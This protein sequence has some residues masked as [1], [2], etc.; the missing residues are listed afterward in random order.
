MITFA[1]YKKKALKDPKVKEMYDELQPDY[2]IIQ[3]L[4]DAKNKHHITQKEL[5]A[6]TG[7]NQAYITRLEKGLANTNLE[8][9]FSSERL[10]EEELESKINAGIPVFGKSLK[11]YSDKM[12][13]GR[14][15]V[16]EG[17]GRVDLLTKDELGNLYVIELKKDSGYE[18]SPFE[19]R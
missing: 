6:I 1:E 19:S 7:I 12:K 18:T 5:S 10:L 11:M 3:A 16:I 2:A 17:V 14:Q 4:I 8:T 13:Y 9:Q 15:Y